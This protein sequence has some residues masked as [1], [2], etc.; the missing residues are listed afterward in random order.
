M[1]R[2]GVGTRPGVAVVSATACTY[3][4]LTR[5]LRAG[6]L[7]GDAVKDPEGAHGGGEFVTFH[8][9]DDGPASP[10]AHRPRAV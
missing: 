6:T 1:E 4:H 3:V 8:V 5:M 2:A 10:H 9:E 7:F